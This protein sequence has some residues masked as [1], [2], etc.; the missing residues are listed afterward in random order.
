MNNIK[1]YCYRTWHNFKRWF[2]SGE[3]YQKH[4]DSH[5]VLMNT[6]YL[7]ISILITVIIYKN[8]D[9]FNDYKLF[10]IKIGSTLL[11]VGLFFTF[12]YLLYIFKQIKNKYHNISNGHKVIIVLIILFLLILVYANQEKCLQKIRKTTNSISGSDFNPIYLS[13]LEHQDIS[14]SKFDMSKATGFIP[15]PWGFLLFWG[16]IIGILLLILNMFVFKGSFPT[17]FI[18]MLVIIGIVIIFQYPIPYNKVDV[19]GYNVFCDNNQVKLRQNIMGIG[20]LGLALECYE[21]KSSQ[22]FPICTDNKPYCQCKANLID[23]IFRQ[24][25]DWMFDAFG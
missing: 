7:A 21:Y 6:L 4:F 15:Q 2:F 18:V 8:I 5:K 23:I 14:T 16:V 22:C 13:G 17:W 3:R 9:F 12:K 10:F 20:E 19:S 25:G 24:E 1:R 11:L